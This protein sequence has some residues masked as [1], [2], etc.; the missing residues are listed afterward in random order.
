MRHAAF[1]EPGRVEWRETPDLTLRGDG[2]ALVRPIVVGRCDLDV[3]YVRGFLPMPAGAPIGHEII[4]EIVDLG[5]AAAGRFRVGQ[6]VFVSAQIACGTCANCRR[7]RTGRCTS[8]PFGSS[9]GMG[10]DGGYG[11]ALAD[12]VRVPFAAAMMSPVP[13]GV[14]PL[15]LIGAA[16]MATD[17]WRAVAPALQA[18]PEARVLVLGGTAP[19]IGLYAVALARALGA[20][21]VV[22]CDD[23]PARSAIAQGYGGTLVSAEALADSGLYDLVV[24]AVTSA[25]ALAA[26]FARVAPGGSIVSV[27]PTLDGFP[28]LDSR[29]LYHK[30]VGWTIGRPDCRPGHDGCM[31]AWANL[32]FCP[33]HV[34]TTTVA[35]EDAPEGWASE[36]IYIAAVRP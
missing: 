8:V 22:Y 31:A 6:Q 1:V 15:T 20:P 29:L 16:D 17:A 19:V 7:G 18:H 35:W 32:G 23:N 28:E 10:R 4:G 5:D 25:A 2:E 26:A 21:Q 13:S 30:G 34:P 33:D 9:Y 24:V 3:A 12:L 11:G 27:V 36:A 14:D